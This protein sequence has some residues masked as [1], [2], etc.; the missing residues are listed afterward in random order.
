M[1]AV[2]RFLVLCVIGVAS[3]V[4]GAQVDRLPGVVIADRDIAPGSTVAV[5]VDVNADALVDLI[6]FEPGGLSQCLVND[7]SGGFQES[8]DIALPFPLHSVEA[9]DLD[10][11][12]APELLLGGATHAYVVRLGSDAPE[13]IERFEAGGAIDVVDFDSDGRADLMVGG[14]LF[15]RDPAGDSYTEIRLPNLR[16]H[17]GDSPAMSPMVGDGDFEALPSGSVAGEQIVDGS[18]SSAKIADGAVRS[19]HLAPEVRARAGLTDAADANAWTHRRADGASRNEGDGGGLV[20]GSDDAKGVSGDLVVTGDLRVHGTGSSSF[21]GSVGVGTPSPANPLDVEGSGTDTGG[22]PSA[23]HVVARVKNANSNLST[24]LSIDAHEDRRSAL[25]FSEA[26]TAQWG[27]QRNPGASGELQVIQYDPDLQTARMRITEEGRVGIGS[28]VPANPL[29]VVGS[30]TDAGGLPGEDRVVARFRNLDD[31]SGTALS[32]DRAGDE[33]KSEIFFAQDGEA[34]WGVGTDKSLLGFETFRIGPVSDGFVQDYFRVGLDGQVGVGK[35]S[36]PFSFP[37]NALDVWGDG[38][39]VGGISGHDQVVARFKNNL[40]GTESAIAV[41]AEPGLD[42]RLYLSSAGAAKWSIGNRVGQGNQLE[43]SWVDPVSGGIVPA[44]T[45]DK[46]GSEGT[47]S[48]FVKVG[49]GTGLPKNPLDVRGEGTEVGGIPS[50][51]HVVARVKNANSNL[52]TALSIDAHEDRRSVLYFASDGDAQWA[53]Q[54]NPG[55]DD[56]FQV[57]QVLGDGSLDTRLAITDEGETQVDVLRIMGGA[58]IVEGF[59]AGATDLAPGTVMVA[60]RARAGRI[61]T[62]DTAY[63]RA[64][65]GVVSGASGV[66]AGL[67]LGQDGRLDGETPVAIAGRV[68]VH[69]SAENGPIGPGDLLTTSGTPGHAMKATNSASGAILGKALGRLEDGRGE[70]LVLV[71][72]Q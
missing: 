47:D 69:C 62:S 58:D 41:D 20:V 57:V 55:S 36:S 67:Y 21:D 46:I 13:V 59:E 71:T 64:V 52:S 6:R 49:N 1:F 45:V 33:G 11:D 2:R 23:G 40:A 18:V 65:I 60:D 24:A 39:S 25:Y 9:R 27:L 63:D 32:V 34:R 43:F 37:F 16:R 29:A 15:R 22:I 8:P 66:R 53:V 35:P 48:V 14:R 12:G 7:G 28:S 54:H 70:V 4:S 10:G 19:R 30:G 56:K 26:G 72:L 44:I 3:V 51:G 50:A 31:T 68:F 5:W 38:S 17:S 61:T 42:T